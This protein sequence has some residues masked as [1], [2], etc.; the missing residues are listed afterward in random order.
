MNGTDD[1]SNIVKLTYREHYIAHLLLAKAYPKNYSLQ[2]A[3]HRMKNSIFFDN[4]IKFNSYVYDSVIKNRNLLVS[5]YSKKYMQNKTVFKNKETGEFKIL[6]VND[7]L[8]LCKNY[9]GVNSGRVYN[10]T[11]GY[12]NRVS[13][14]TE[15]GE[16]KSVSIEEYKNNPNLVG[17]NSG[18]TGLWDHYNFLYS[19]MEWYEK[20][21]FRS[22]K[23]TKI[24]P[25]VII[26][27]SHIFELSNY[28]KEY[29]A[30]H[31]R[32]SYNY[33]NLKE[34]FPDLFYKKVDKPLGIV[35]NK[36]RDG[37]D[38]LTDDKFLDALEIFVTIQRSNS[39]ESN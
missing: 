33:K 36:L 39:N 9:V 38:P 31:N 1:S 22:Y 3:V 24:K 23:K 16:Y 18:K 26:L 11:D 21:M 30:A 29:F 14:K 28:V 27:F 10:N 4:S 35:L 5:E 34:K 13:V 6:D 12:K 2:C 20:L 25:G 17:V 8:V 37:W 32:Y 7:P 15:T 19:Q